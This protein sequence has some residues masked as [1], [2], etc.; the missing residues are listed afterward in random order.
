MALGLS[1]GKKKQSGSSSTDLTKDVTTVG[2]Q[3]QNQQQATQQ[4]Q[5]TSSTGSSSTVGSQSG[6]TTQ[7]STG[8]E[9]GRQTGTTTSLGADV[10]AAF[11]ERVQSILGKGVTDAN[12][13]NLSNLISGR[14]DFD[15]DSMV[16]GIVGAARNRGEQTL[17]EQNSSFAARTGGTSDTNSMA[18]LL[19]QRGRNDLESNLAGIEGQARAQAEG[20]A[21]QNL[22]AAAGAQ[23]QV[24]DIATQLGTVLKGATTTTDMSTLTSQIQSL[25]GTS[26]Q[27]SRSDTATAEQQQSQMNQLLTSLT[28]LLSQSNESTVGSENTKTKGKTS[29]GGLSLGL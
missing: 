4:N 14:S 6:T 10:T 12:L 8:Q 29:G 15:A 11:S 17:Q 21:N 3:T 27:T 18:A 7:Q 16:S 19:A 25:L 28:Q 1:F 5:S 9:S 23:G 24:A 22:T 2:S 26:D 20:I 13:D